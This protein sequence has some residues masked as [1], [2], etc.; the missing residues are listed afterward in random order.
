MDG[1]RTPSSMQALAGA[2]VAADS[3]AR[4]NCSVQG[5]RCQ[6]ADFWLCELWRAGV[7]V[8]DE[9]VSAV[10]IAGLRTGT[11]MS[12]RRF[13]NDGAS[14]VVEAAWIGC[15]TAETRTVRKPW[16]VGGGLWERIEPLL[17]V[18]ERR[19][20]HPGRKRLDD[21]KALCGI[22]FVLHTRIPWRFLPTELGFGS[23]MTCWRRL[24]EWHE[25]GV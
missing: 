8:N 15:E 9:V 14:G 11:K 19:F 24:R 20:R 16:E 21:R 22:L 4:A 25:A 2:C 18:I 6:I 5:P 3:S 10:A 13:G 12:R 23:G 1:L 17:P 7:V